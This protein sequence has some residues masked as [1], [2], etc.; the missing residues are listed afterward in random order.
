M[1]RRPT[2][3]L[4]FAEKKGR[5]DFVVKS[6]SD[7]QTNFS[8]QCAVQPLKNETL[9]DIEIFCRLRDYVATVCFHSLHDNCRGLYDFSYDRQ[10]HN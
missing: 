7:E 4:D 5:R 1:V 9:S 8:N 10:M 3:A 2:V 6:P